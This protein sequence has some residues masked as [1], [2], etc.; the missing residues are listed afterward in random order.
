MPSIDIVK[1][2]EKTKEHGFTRVPFELPDEVE[3]FTLYYSYDKAKR[4]LPGNGA[5][6]RN[7]IDLAILTPSGESAGCSG[8]SKASVYI[9]AHYATPGYRPQ[10]IEAGVWE[11]L[12]GFNMV[13]QEGVTITF[14]IEYELK[15]YRWLKGDPH[16]HTLHSDGKLTTAGLTTLAKKV[17]LDWIVITDH[18][19][20]H[21]DTAIPENRG[22]LA[23][24]GVELTNFAGHVN[25][26]G[27]VRPFKGAYNAESSEE[28]KAIVDEARANGATVSV[29][30]PTCK[31]CGFHLPLDNFDYECVELWNGPMRIDNM[32]GIQ[33]WHEQLL[34]GRRLSGVGG[35]DYH[36]DYIVTNLLGSPTTV[37]YAK[38]LSETDVLAALRKGAC[39]VT[40]DPASCELYLTSGEL[41]MGD[42]VKLTDDTVVKL[43]CSKLKRGQRLIVYNNDEI[44]YEHKGTG[45]H[46]AELKGL[47]KGF[48]RA[49]ILYDKSAIGKFLYHQLMKI[50]LPADAKLDVPSFAWALT[51]PIYLI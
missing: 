12:I 16:T 43:Y 37:A 10:E 33:W 7:S 25:F 15:H 47:K 42:E 26:W 17:G 18:N 4:L 1:T 30:H 24:R 49:E 8:C 40:H 32:T 11:A 5:A 9:S 44:I 20:A 22:L 23:M 14:H 19:V 27:A 34:S 39:Y 6:D 13:K 50:M 29:N 36:R 41:G 35:S 2:Y 51:N 46:T 48:V 38:S 31:N 45:S 28:L 21:I 3:S